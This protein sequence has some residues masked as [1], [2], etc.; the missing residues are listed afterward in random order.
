MSYF[1]AAATKSNPA[2]TQASAF[3]STR[4]FKKIQDTVS[5]ANVTHEKFLLVQQQLAAH[6][7]EVAEKARQCSAVGKDEKMRSTAHEYNTFLSKSGIRLTP[8]SPPLSC[9]THADFRERPVGA[10]AID[11]VQMRARAVVIQECLQAAA[12]SALYRPPV[13]PV[14]PVL[15]CDE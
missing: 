11:V 13:E 5:P 8:A 12:E 14:V 1:F 6:G 2:L 3:D 9:E 4:A 10:H 15:K 7:A